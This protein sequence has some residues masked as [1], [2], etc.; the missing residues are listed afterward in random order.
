MLGLL[1]QRAFGVFIVYVLAS[2]LKFM[3]SAQKFFD[4]ENVNGGVIWLPREEQDNKKP[5]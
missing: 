1:L 5:Q 3:K 4:R 2:L